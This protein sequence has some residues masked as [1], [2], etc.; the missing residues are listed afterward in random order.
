METGKYIFSN[1]IVEID[2]IYND[3]KTGDGTI[4][5]IFDNRLAQDRQETLYAYEMGWEMSNAQ[6]ISNGEYHE[7]Y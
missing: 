6:F 4:I 3:N 2:K 1:C 7:L 5:C